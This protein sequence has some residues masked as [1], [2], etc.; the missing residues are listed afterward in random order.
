MTAPF[1]FDFVRKTPLVFAPPLAHAAHLERCQAAD[2]AIDTIPY[3]SHVTGAD[4]L[5]VGVPLVTLIGPAER[6]E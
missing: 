1:E 3:G 2:L 4:A 5:S 6:S